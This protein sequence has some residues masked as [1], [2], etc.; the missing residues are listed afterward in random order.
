MG[1][2]SS[3]VA[4]VAPFALALGALK[5]AREA[6]LDPY[7]RGDA[8]RNAALAS[9]M[10]FLALSLSPVGVVRTFSRAAKPPPAADW[11]P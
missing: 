7:S 6:W 2:L 8:I 4:P 1:G 9:V 10:L 3:I 5:R 11:R